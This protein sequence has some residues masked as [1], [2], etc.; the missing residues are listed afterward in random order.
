MNSTFCNRSLSFNRAVLN[1]GGSCSSPKSTVKNSS[2][3][4]ELL[5]VSPNSINLK[6][7]ISFIYTVQIANKSKLPYCS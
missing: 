7:I 4:N 3:V 2:V 1:E 6:K 5:G